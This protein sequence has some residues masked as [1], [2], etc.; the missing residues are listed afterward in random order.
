MKNRGMIMIEIIVSIFL[1]M[2]LIFPVMKFNNKM[3]EVNRKID[4]YT[5]SKINFDYLKAYFKSKNIDFYKNK[6]GYYD[7]KNNF[8]MDINLPY[9][10][11]DKY[12]VNIIQTPITSNE[13]YEYI[14]V[15]IMYTINN[16][17]YIEKFLVSR[18]SYE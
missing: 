3:L 6:I 17:Q 16:K 5:K 4:T 2:A 11:K 15:E 8:L 14:T 18:N 10:L 12:A 7:E 9:K 1:F 13:I